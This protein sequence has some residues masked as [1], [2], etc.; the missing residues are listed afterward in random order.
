MKVLVSGG[1]GFIGRALM[2]RLRARKD[3]VRVITRD[4]VKAAFELGQDVDCV[5][6]AADP[7]T[8]LGGAEAVVSLLGEPIFGRRWT[9]A[10]KKRIRESRVDG[11]QRLVAAMRAVAPE[12]RP[13][14]FVS[15]SAI[16]YYG[17]RGDQELFEDA[18]SG[19]DFLA[20]VCREWE[21]AALE[22]A[23]LGIRVVIVRTGIVLGPGGGALA[24]MLPIFRLGGGGPIG[25]GSQFMS[26]IHLDDMA[27][28]IVHA[29]VTPSLTGPVNG[30]A[31]NPV[32]N[33]AFGKALGK[34][35]HRPAFVPTPRLAL[36]VIFGES[37]DIL[38]TGQRVVPR[39]AVASGF[40]FA[41]PDL[42]PAL[43]ACVPP[44]RRL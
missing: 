23:D 7:K 30:T 37:A 10:Q 22:A 12:A 17:P 8:L 36:R 29:I 5:S 35:L 1:T 28:L 39:K 9:A 14:V 38:A 6:L 40:T 18:P 34:V 21:K 4:P 3:S 44:D 27:S 11:T 15:G 19:D 42:E 32:T 41:F 16:G 24:Q 13:K 33:K 43:R 25:S 2:R 20:E 26:W 31:P